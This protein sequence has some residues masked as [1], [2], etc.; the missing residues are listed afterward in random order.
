MSNDVARTKRFMRDPPA[1]VK[2]SFLIAK[3]IRKAI[4]RILYCIGGGE[5]KVGAAIS[6]LGFGT[7]GELLQPVGLPAVGEQPIGSTTPTPLAAMPL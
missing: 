3:E 4:E 6:D 5:F 7:A 1:E 2:V